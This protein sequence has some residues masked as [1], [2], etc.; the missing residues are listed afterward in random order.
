M[1]LRIKADIVKSKRV[2]RASLA[3]NLKAALER[4][5]SF[6][7]FT[8]GA[9]DKSHPDLKLPYI[10]LCVPI[11]VQK[12][13]AI[14]LLFGFQQQRRRSMRQAG[15]ESVVVGVLF[16]QPMERILSRKCGFHSVAETGHV[17][18]LRARQSVCSGSSNRSKKARS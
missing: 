7:K 13:E 10:G 8:D 14:T 18:H 9:Y 17:I 1:S 12:D 16:T 6:A 2:A 5:I 3:T 15:D 11:Y 4:G